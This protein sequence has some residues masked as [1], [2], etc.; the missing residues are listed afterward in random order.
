MCEVQCYVHVLYSYLMSVSKV[1]VLINPVHMVHSHKQAIQLIIKCT[2]RFQPLKSQQVEAMMEL[3][4]I[5][6]LSC[7]VGRLLVMEI[8]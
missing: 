4:L 8:G 5:L 1:G 2:L 3:T 6:I 7:F